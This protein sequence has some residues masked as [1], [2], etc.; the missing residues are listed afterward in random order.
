MTEVSIT[1][2]SFSDPIFVRRT[3]CSHVSKQDNS[4]P[5]E[6][7]AGENC[8][9]SPCSENLSHAC[10]VHGDVLLVSSLDLE[11]GYLDSFFGAGFEEH[12]LV[13][14]RCVTSLGV[15]PWTVSLQSSETTSGCLVNWVALLR[16]CLQQLS[17]STASDQCKVVLIDPVSHHLSIIHIPYVPQTLPQFKGHQEQAVQVKKTPKIP[18]NQ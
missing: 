12:W 13:S 1:R 8:W 4:P 10:H 17:H 14:W 7:A 2:L 18:E 9:S 16:S 11:D 3:K 6:N 5:W 15:P